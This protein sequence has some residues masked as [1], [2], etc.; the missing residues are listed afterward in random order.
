MISRAKRAA[1]I[2]A[3]LTS[4]AITEAERDAIREQ[5]KVRKTQKAKNL[6]AIL[7]PEFTMPVR[8]PNRFGQ[9]TSV[10]KTYRYLDISLPTGK[11]ALMFNPKQLYCRT[12]TTAAWTY[13]ATPNAT[14]NTD[15]ISGFDAL[16][17]PILTVYNDITSSGNVICD[18]STRYMYGDNVFDYFDD[19]ALRAAVVRVYYIG[20]VLQAKGYMCGAIDYSQNINDVWKSPPNGSNPWNTALVENG[21]YKR[22]GDP[23]SGMRFIWYP[24]D[25][26]DLMMVTEDESKGDDYSKNQQVVYIYGIN[27]D[28][29]ATLRV[30]VVRHIEGLP[31]ANVRAYMNIKRPEPGEPDDIYEDLAE[32][33]SDIGD[34][35]SLNLKEAS[36]VKDSVSEIINEMYSDDIAPVYDKYGSTDIRY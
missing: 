7:F 27:L 16:S 34:L 15:F 17:Y 30:D 13:K 20:S 25:E 6:I 3:Y 10:F 31:K 9:L 24:K 5:L 29:G 4:D 2:L 21:H 23:D 11:F 19:C 36:Q 8:L 32:I 18:S 22:F 35:I 14:S 33:S 26:E 12:Q 1:D 28:S